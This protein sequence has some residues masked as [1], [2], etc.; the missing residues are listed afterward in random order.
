MPDATEA[1]V[2]VPA[3]EVLAQEPVKACPVCP[4]TKKDLDECVVINGETN[5]GDLVEAHKQCM[6]DLG[7]SI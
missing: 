6:R 3:E 7:F 5:C 4:G 1:I 2:P